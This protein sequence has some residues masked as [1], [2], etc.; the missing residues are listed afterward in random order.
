MAKIANLRSF[1][2]N[3]IFEISAFS[4]MIAYEGSIV[5]EMQQHAIWL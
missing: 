4:F 3:G 2:S 5:I 1:S